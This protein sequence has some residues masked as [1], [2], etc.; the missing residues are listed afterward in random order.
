MRSRLLPTFL[1]AALLA[2]A[3]ALFSQAEKKPAAR[4]DPARST[5]DFKALMQKNLEAW[6]TLDP[7]NAAPFY[8]KQADQVFFDVAPLK[9]AG[10]T[11]Y[12]EGAKKIL[13]GFASLKFTLGDDVRTHQHGNLAWATATWHGD[14]VMKEGAPVPLDGRW[15]VVWE[16]RGKDWLIVHEHVSIPMA[17]PVEKAGQSLYKRLGGYDAIAAV[18]D[19]FIGRLAKDPQ[20]AKFFSSHS[21]DSLHR[22]RQLVVD[23][24]CEATGGPC[25]YIGRDM[26]TSHAGLG[27]T[28]SDWQ[29]AVNHLVATLDKFNVP[30][31]EKEEVLNAISGLKKDI[32]T[33][34]GGGQ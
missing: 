18:T 22:I 1:L 15:T 29:A 4:R 25:L 28:E 26:K 14:A 31:K 7:A 5:T 13:A 30:P 20:L 3:P 16:R 19:D 32:V 33:P 6:Q 17:P 9:Y 2:G 34:G 10:W 21:T 12:A 23:Q 11:E 24:L 8:A 27:I